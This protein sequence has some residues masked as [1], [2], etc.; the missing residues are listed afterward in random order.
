MRLEIQAYINRVKEK[1]HSLTTIE[2]GNGNLDGYEQLIEILSRNEKIVQQISEIRMSR[3]SEPLSLN[4]LMFKNLCKLDLSLCDVETLYLPLNLK[5]L[6]VS[7]NMC[8]VGLQKFIVD[9]KLNNLCDVIYDSDYSDVEECDSGI[10]E[11]E[12]G[13][14]NNN[15]MQYVSG[16]LHSMTLHSAASIT[17]SQEHNN[18]SCQQLSSSNKRMRRMGSMGAMGC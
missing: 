12:G 6:K 17:T 9:L 1:D 8:S 15:G 2:L 3:I 10:E 7:N 14:Q 16:M 5:E 18:Y 4:L 13:L 11:E